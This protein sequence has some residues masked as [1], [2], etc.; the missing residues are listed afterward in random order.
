M[1]ETA[2]DPAPAAETAE[3]PESAAAGPAAAAAHLDVTVAGAGAGD[4]DRAVA[5]LDPVDLARIGAR[6]GDLLRLEAARV[7]YA[8]ALPA[9]PAER[10]RRLALLDSVQRANLR[11]GLGEAVRVS[12]AEGAPAEEVVL[13]L[14]GGVA[15]LTPELLE[16]VKNAML[17]TPAFAG[18]GLRA[19]LVGGRTLTLEIAAT[20]PG[21]PVIVTEATRLVVEGDDAETAAPRRAETAAAAPGGY[22]ALGGLAPEIAQVREMVELPLK[23]PDLF[24]RLG[25]DAPRG[26]LFTGPPGSG[27]TLLARAVAEECGAAFFVLDAP[28]VMS[29]HYGDSEAKLR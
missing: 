4:A 18:D 11:V 6:S 13:T 17:S 24:R 10:G 2:P 14:R 16:R 29:K 20:R 8:R 12:R 27:K 22:A 26:V 19:R 9:H 3:T 25:V 1:S 7:T 15:R 23:R 28:S 21:G 5:R